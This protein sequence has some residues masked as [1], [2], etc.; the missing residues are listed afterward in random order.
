MA[1]IRKLGMSPRSVP[2]PL[3]KLLFANVI[4]EE[5]KNAASAPNAKK[6]TKQKA[7]GLAESVFAGKVIKKYRCMGLLQKYAQV[8]RRVL[9]THHGKLVYKRKKRNE[10]RSD[11]LK[12]QVISYLE[13]DDNSRMLPGKADCTKGKDGKVQKRILNDYLYNLY[14]KFLAWY[15]KFFS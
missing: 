3:K 8:G 1:E 12:K 10:E 13:R 15:K 4:M 6:G 5:L 2:R 9:N 11:E 7:K 14:K